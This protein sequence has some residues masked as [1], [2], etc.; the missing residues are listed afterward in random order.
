MFPLL[1]EIGDGL[2]E[3]GYLAPYR[4][5]GDTLLVA[6]DGTDFLRFT[7]DFLPLFKHR[8]TEHYRSMNQLPL[9]DSDDALMLNGCELTI[10]DDKGMIVYKNAWATTHLITNDNVAEI[11]NSGRARWKTENENNNLLKNHGYHFEHN[12]GH[13][14]QHLSN[15]LAT[16]ILAY[17]PVSYR[18]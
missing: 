13:G 10:T 18:A 2:H 7:E 9:R 1:Q 17:L 14:K 11:T 8:F 4:A 16:L 6:F 12:F 3:H 15:V 5:V